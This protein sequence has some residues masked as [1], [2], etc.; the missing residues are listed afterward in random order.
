MRAMSIALVWFRRDLRVHDNRALVAALNDGHVPIPVYVHAPAEEAPWVPGGASRWW[1]HHSLAAL[2]AALRDRG[3]RLVLADGPS[4]G[5][6]GDLVRRTGAAAV[7][8]ERLYEPHLARRDR[9]VARALEQAGVAARVLPGG[10]LVEPEAVATR[11]GT[12]FRVFGAYWRAWRRTVDGSGGPQPAPAH[13]PAPRR[14][15]RGHAPNALGVLP[16]HP[17][18]GKLA[19]TWTP[20]E[21][22]GLQR[23]ADFVDVA[24]EGYA[25]SRDLPGEDG[26]SRLSPRLHFGEISARQVWRAVIN[27]PGGAGVEAY[28][29]QLAWRDFAYHLLHHFPDMAER[30]LD[31]RFDAFPWRRRYGTL[32]RRWQ[33]GRTGYPMVDAGMRELWHT[34]WMHNRARML[35]AS[36]LV[37]NCRIPWQE[38]A[39]WFW[40]TLV[41]AD[42]ANNTLGWQWTAGTGPDAAPYFR[43][44]NPTRQGQR[45]DAGGE[46][47]CRWVPELAGLSA[48]QLHQ[49]HGRAAGDYPPPMVDFAD[50]R[51]EALAGYQRVRSRRR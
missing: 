42:L 27:A 4:A 36:L 8:W 28:L 48:A 7:Y 31:R 38:G 44:F 50:S 24:L 16:E 49:P 41:D 29:R 45:F 23:L 3:S 9:G 11:S 6:L 40:D 37:K 26:V 13:L 30:S 51:R 33:Q 34:G 5:A 25:G 10:L 46:Y 17:W 32:L 47:T 35:A 43:I 19:R 1:L 12:P 14:W 18:T 39:R 20:G 21:A 15:P 22:A 2:D